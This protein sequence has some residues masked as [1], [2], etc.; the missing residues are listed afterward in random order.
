MAYAQDTSS[1]LAFRVYMKQQNG[2]R[3]GPYHICTA[4][5]DYA[6]IL[7]RK[8]VWSTWLKSSVSSAKIQLLR[9]ITK[10]QF[11]L[12]WGFCTVARLVWSLC[13][14][15]LQWLNCAVRFLRVVWQKNTVVL[16]CYYAVRD[17]SRICICCRK[18]VK[19]MCRGIGSIAVKR[20]WAIIEQVKAV[21]SFHYL[22]A[23]LWLNE[24]N[25]RYAVCSHY[26]ETIQR[27]P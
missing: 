16:T 26:F 8:I 27:I 17:L 7:K 2:S 22:Y 21:S 19:E 18:V 1:N 10:W 25:E 15:S 5:D 11:I 3:L 24:L 12:S 4:D 20:L 6:W 9:H 23:F 13:D 14:V